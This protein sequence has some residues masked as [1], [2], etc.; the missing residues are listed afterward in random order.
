MSDDD[1]TA[2][3]PSTSSGADVPST[4]SGADVLSTSS[5]ADVLSTSYADWTS[6]NTDE[7]QAQTPQFIEESEPPLKVL[8]S[9]LYCIFGCVIFWNV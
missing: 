9:N 6:V 5:G 3:V 4:S 2:D 8:L 7:P 1:Q